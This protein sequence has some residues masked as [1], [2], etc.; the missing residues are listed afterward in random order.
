MHLYSVNFLATSIS[1]PGKQFFS[2]VFR[3]VIMNR[4]QRQI[5]T[6]T[7]FFCFPFWLGWT[8]VHFRLYIL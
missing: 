6:Q 3:I 7:I 5:Y 1:Q 2:A 4:Q 8:D